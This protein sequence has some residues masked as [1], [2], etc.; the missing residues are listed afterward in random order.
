MSKISDK[1]ISFYWITSICFFWGGA[2]FLLGTQC[3]R[4]YSEQKPTT[5]EGCLFWCANAI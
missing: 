4:V 5:R 1:I 2:Y 3:T